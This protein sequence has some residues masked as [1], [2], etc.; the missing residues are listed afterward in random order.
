MS[1][2]HMEQG[3]LTERFRTFAQSVDPEPKR[4]ARKALLVGGAI[5]VLLA[6]VAIW[7]LLA[8]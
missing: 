3:E 7:V 4:T 6:L 1:E 5:V 8:D 2:D